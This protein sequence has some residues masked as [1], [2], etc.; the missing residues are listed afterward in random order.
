MS[1]SFVQ[2]N[3]RNHLIMAANWKKK[4]VLKKMQK[5]W[6]QDRKNKRNKR[7]KKS[8]ELMLK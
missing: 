6:E 7:R 2:M 3:F 5:L 4:S 8:K 1:L